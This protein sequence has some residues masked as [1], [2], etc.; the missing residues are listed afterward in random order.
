MEIRRTIVSTSK[1]PVRMKKTR[2]CAHCGKE[3]VVRSGMQRY[4]SEQCQA[5]AKEERKRRLREFVTA[6]EPAIDLKNQ[7]YLTFRVR[8]ARRR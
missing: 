3:F 2:E 7:D 5:K 4:C 8:L 1:N 6:I